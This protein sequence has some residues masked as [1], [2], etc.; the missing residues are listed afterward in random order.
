MNEENYTGQTCYV[1]FELGIQDFGCGIP[2][3]KLDSLFINFNNLEQHHKKNPA[4][5]GLGLSICKMIVESMGGTVKVQSEEGKGSIFSI[6]F[7]VMCKVPED[8]LLKSSR[9][10]ELKELNSFQNISR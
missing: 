3:D 2:K 7:K 9:H 10:K 4:G 6:I 5:R 8:R 1:K